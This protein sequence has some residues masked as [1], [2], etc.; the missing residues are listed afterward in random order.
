MVANKKLKAFIQKTLLEDEEV[1]WTCEGC[2]AKWSSTAYLVF[3]AC[4]TGLGL[5]FMGPIVLMADWGAGLATSPLFALIALSI[6]L[7]WFLTFLC[8]VM[9]LFRH[10]SFAYAVTNRRVRVFKT[11][12]FISA[13]SVWPDEIQHVS[14][15]QYK[16]KGTGFLFYYTFLAWDWEHWSR[17]VVPTNRMMNITEPNLAGDLI[18]Q[19]LL[20]LRGTELGYDPI[21]G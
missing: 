3:V 5:F 17:S 6:P 11:A 2:S 14:V 16:D 10:R 13:K 18:R 12:L 20:P 19:H 1:L 8:S 15:A 9:E 21:E 4:F 7:I